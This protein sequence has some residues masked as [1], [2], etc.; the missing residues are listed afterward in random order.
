MN[1]LGIHCGHNASAALMIDGRLVGA[2]QEERFTK[3]KNQVAFPLRAVRALID[4]HLGGDAAALCHVAFATRDVDPVGLALSR[5]SEFDVADHVQEMREYWRPVYYEGRPNDGSYWLDMYRRGEKLN[6]DHNVDAERLMSM[7]MAQAVRLL[8]DV[9]RPAILARALGW[10]GTHE[11]LDHHACHAY[12]GFYGARIAKERW[13]DVLVLTADS[14]G[15]GC[16]WSAWSVAP[17]GRLVEQGSGADHGVARIYRFTTLILGMKPNEHEYK[18]MGLSGYSRSERHIAAAERVFYEALD[19][20]DGR[21]VRTRPL[22][23]SYFDLKERLEGHRFDNIAAALQNWSTAV[24][25]AWIRHWL[26]GLGKRILCFSGGLSMNIKSNGEFARMT[27][28]DDISVPASGGDETTSLG[29]CFMAARMR[30]GTAPEAM[31]HVYLGPP[32]TLGAESDWREGVR[33]AGADPADFAEIERVDARAIAMLLAA[34]QIVAR[35][36]GPMEF[37][38]RALGNRSILADPSKAANIKRINDAIKNRDFWMPFTPSILAEKASRYLVNP[39]GIIAP[40]MTV[41]Y[42]TTPLARTHLAAAVHPGDYS[43]RPQFVIREA[44]PAY[45]ELI[46]AFEE[47]T[48]VSAVL[49]TSLNLHGDPMNA[50]V[51]DAARTLALS[52]LDCL[53][54]PGQRLLCKRDALDRLRGIIGA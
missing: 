47:I 50:S 31:P 45:W 52:A 6:R 22:K 24:T 37:G 49:N 18:V 12:Y 7:P 44:N 53:A 42:D 39:R 30:D 14:W 38:A 41:G 28:L 36:D 19:F 27:E 21:F 11:V 40:F 43:A 15:D 4:T 20:H 29:A 9:E 3:R 34:D 23:D 1:I 5:Y 2:V 26:A 35:C 8:S 46:S 54:L 51:A 25:R 13:Q 16:N 17:D 48:G 32:A 33:R 10:K